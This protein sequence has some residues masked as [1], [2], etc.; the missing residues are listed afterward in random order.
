MLTVAAHFRVEYQRQVYEQ[1]SNQTIPATMKVN[2]LH[3]TLWLSSD[4]VTTIILICVNQRIKCAIHEY[5][6]QYKPL[7]PLN[8]H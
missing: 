4:A 6:A 8:E 5:T 1:V 3:Q 7:G 2:D